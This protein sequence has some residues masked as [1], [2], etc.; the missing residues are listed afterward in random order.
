MGFTI[1]PSVSASNNCGLTTGSSSIQQPIT[2]N[3]IFQTLGT[4]FSS[5]QEQV[6]T[7]QP[8]SPCILS[9]RNTN[10]T[11]LQQN[12]YKYQFIYLYDLED[13]IAGASNPIIEGNVIILSHDQ[14][15]L[16]YGIALENNLTINGILADPELSARTAQETCL[17]TTALLAGQYVL[18]IQQALPIILSKCPVDVSQIANFHPVYFIDDYTF[19]TICGSDT[20]K[21]ST[22]GVM[23]YQTD[24]PGNP[25]KVLLWGTGFT[26]FVIPV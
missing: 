19:T 26:E 3:Y 18:A 4:I 12:G 25:I 17:S 21:T 23:R 24:L 11:E 15:R 13:F 9:S 8:T 6:K 10:F 5:D 1:Y 7:I 16:N 20:T 2:A 22:V 14:I